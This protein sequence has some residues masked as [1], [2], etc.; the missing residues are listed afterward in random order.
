MSP[1]TTDVRPQ[2]L[3]IYLRQSTHYPE[4]PR[5]VQ[6][7]ETHISWVF[8]TDR[9]VYKLKKPVRFEFLDFSTPEARRQACQQEVKLNRRLAPDVYLDV[10]GL[11]PNEHG[12]WTWGDTDHP[13]EW[14]VKMRRLPAEACLLERL[15]RETIS[16]RELELL[17]DFLATFYL[18]Q[19]P[20]TLVPNR[21]RER[22][23]E[24]IESN[25]RDLLLDD[26]PH[27][28]RIRHLHQAQL[29]LL[30]ERASLFDSRVCDGRFIEGH[31]DLRPE[32]IYLMQRPAVIDCIEFSDV[33]R[34]IDIV[35]EL[36]FLTME[37]DRL[38]HHAVGSRIMSRYVEE[39][40]D[41]PPATLLAFYKAYRACV[42]AKVLALRSNQALGEERRLYAAQ[43]EGYLDLA[44]RYV[45]RFQPQRLI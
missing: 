27:Q 21:V 16:E 3:E 1:L 31:G 23:R 15:Q 44:E 32:H 7:V 6:M 25:Q 18:Q 38:G 43:S 42:R 33:M 40:K 11:S 20:L 10:I 34:K 36:G 28:D 5:H 39:T 26:A 9:Y 12:G 29:D 30:E 35:D 4:R 41:D 45:Q 17:A 13:T 8:L 37:C 19:P 24:M 2:P 22:L 14:L